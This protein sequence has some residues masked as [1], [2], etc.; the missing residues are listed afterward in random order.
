MIYHVKNTTL[1]S[2]IQVFSKKGW[3][4]G[5]NFCPVGRFLIKKE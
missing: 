1:I 3:C 2:F 5:E 4:G